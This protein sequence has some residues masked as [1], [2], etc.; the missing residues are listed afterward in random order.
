[1]E[2][3]SFDITKKRYYIGNK[4]EKKYLHCGDNINFMTDKQ[5]KTGKVSYSRFITKG[6]YIS[7][8]YGKNYIPLFMIKNILT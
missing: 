6:Y 3:L 8:N 5:E 1:M 2:K 7:L 4:D